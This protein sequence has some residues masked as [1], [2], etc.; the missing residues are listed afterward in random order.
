MKDNCILKKYVYKVRKEPAIMIEQYHLKE[1]MALERRR[2]N[3]PL[4]TMIYLSTNPTPTLYPR[5][6]NRK[7]TASLSAGFSSPGTIVPVAPAPVT[8]VVVVVPTAPSAVP[9]K[10]SAAPEVAVFPA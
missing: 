5:L 1:L 7:N 3:P 9:V 4:M 6:S 10:V 2:R 8:V